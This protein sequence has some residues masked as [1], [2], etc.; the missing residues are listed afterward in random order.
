MRKGSDEK[1][2]KC[3]N[4]IRDVL[5][6]HSVIATIFLANGTGHGEYSLETNDNWSLLQ[7]VDNGIRIKTDKKDPLRMDKLQKTVNAI[8]VIDGMQSGMNENFKSI[9]DGL[10]SKLEIDESDKG[11]FSPRIY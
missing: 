1:L 9:K 4:E 11:I 2:I 7:F 8:W 10:R 5:K 3:M 6:K